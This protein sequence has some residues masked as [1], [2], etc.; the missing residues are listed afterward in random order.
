[1]PNLKNRVKN[2]V[3]KAAGSSFWKIF[4]LT[5]SNILNSAATDLT[6]VA[7]GDLIIEQVILATASTGLAAGTNFEISVNGETYGIDKPIVEA[8]SNLGASAQRQY[9]SGVAAETTNDNQITVTCAVPIVLQ[10]GD[11]LQYGSSGADCTGAGTILVALKF[12]RVSENAN[13]N[14]AVWW[15]LGWL[16]I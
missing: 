13:I 3:V 7:S 6:S 2:A 10:A 14:S 16:I 8:V 4:V 1:M 15:F 11:K 9:P 12:V 5:S